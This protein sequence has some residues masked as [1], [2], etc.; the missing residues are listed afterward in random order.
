MI[1]FLI[2]RGACQLRIVCELVGNPSIF[3]SR[4]TVPFVCSFLEAEGSRSSKK[5]IANSKL[6]SISFI[7]VR[8]FA[9]HQIIGFHCPPETTD[10]SSAFLGNSSKVLPLDY[11]YD[12][13]AYHCETKWNEKWENSHAA[14]NRT[15]KRKVANTTTPTKRSTK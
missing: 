3:L 8:I 13:D 1:A 2:T 15:R 6:G 10:G 7:I 11:Y 9:D 12:V 4:I 5:H 14:N